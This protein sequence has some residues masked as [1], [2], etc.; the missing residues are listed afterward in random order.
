MT[1]A[2][3]LISVWQQVLAEGKDWVELGGERYHVGR[4]RSRKLRR[5]DFEFGGVPLT[6]IEQNPQTGSRWAAM[7]RQGKRI[8]Q[9]S[10]EGR[11]FANV[12]EG[13]LTR[14]PAWRDLDLPD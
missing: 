13:R 4:T 9:F 8:L 12:V 5:V 11:Y 3:A 1:L 10:C 14:Y 6:G 2:E 7:A